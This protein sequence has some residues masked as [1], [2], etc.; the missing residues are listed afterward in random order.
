MINVWKIVVQ[1]NCVVREKSEKKLLK[2]E[3]KIEKVRKSWEIVN[4]GAG[5]NCGGEKSE[6]K[7]RK[8]RK[9]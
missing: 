8:E 6:R 1:G 4:C 9:R 3:K 5:K 7:E 2:S